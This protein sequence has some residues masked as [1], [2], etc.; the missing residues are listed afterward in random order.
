MKICQ[1]IG[2]VFMNM[3]I[4]MS[5]CRWIIKTY[6]SNSTYLPYLL[7]LSL[8]RVCVVDVNVDEALMWKLMLISD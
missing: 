6:F 4:C 2:K 7:L 5:N 1:V 8:S 3:G